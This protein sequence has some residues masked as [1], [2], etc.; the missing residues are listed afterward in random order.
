MKQQPSRKQKLSCECEV[1]EC[2]RLAQ[3]QAQSLGGSPHTHTWQQGLGE[4]CP[5]T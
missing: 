2:G 3:R 1:S 5:P 4:Q